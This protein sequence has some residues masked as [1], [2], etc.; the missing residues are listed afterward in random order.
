[1]ASEAMMRRGRRPLRSPAGSRSACPARCSAGAYLSQYVGGLHPC[2]MCYWQRWPHFAAVVPRRA[3]F[4]IRRAEPQRPPADRARRARD[5]RLGR[6]RGVSCR[7]RIWLVGRADAL[8]E[9]RRDD[10][11]GHHERAAGAL[12]PGAV[13]LPDR[14][15]WPA[16]MRSSR[17]ARPPL[18]VDP[19]QARP[20]HDRLAPGDRAARHAPACC[21]STRPANMA[22]R[23]FMPDSSP[24]SP[25]VATPRT[26]SPAWRVRSSATSTAST[27]CW[28]SAASARPRSSRCGTSPASCSARRP[29]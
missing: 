28:P 29:R 18:I 19:A 2:E 21:A 16:G 27:P 23:G 6:D 10:A 20:A 14:S 17:S 8:R 9:R 3:R 24:C 26:R 25:R 7:G 12:R 4:P 1:M 15:A 11:R 13:H 5:R 22:R